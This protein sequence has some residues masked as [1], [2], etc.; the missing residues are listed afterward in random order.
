MKKED[1][2]SGMIVETRNR[3]L[4]IVLLNTTN[5][6]IIGGAGGNENINTWKPLDSFD[7]NLSSDFP[8]CDIVKI[9]NASSNMYFGTFDT[10]KLNCI[11]ERPVDIK[12]LTMEEIADK[13]GIDVS[14]LRIV[15]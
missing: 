2:R 1:L 6:D 10:S 9:Y 13:F 12:E 8:Q 7:D 11:W 5:G 3:K 14:L 15:K 4:G